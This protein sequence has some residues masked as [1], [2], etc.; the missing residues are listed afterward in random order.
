L[1]GTIRQRVE[2]I[3]SAPHHRAQTS[4]GSAT[5]TSRSPGKDWVTGGIAVV[6][7]LV[8]LNGPSKE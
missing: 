2:S 5:A 8:K 1:Y 7:E 3:R 4:A 6:E